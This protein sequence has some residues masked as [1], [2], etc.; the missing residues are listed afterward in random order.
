MVRNLLNF[1][2]FYQNTFLCYPSHPIYCALVQVS[3]L[4]LMLAVGWEG[5]GVGSCAYHQKWLAVML[6][7]ISGGIS[8]TQLLRWMPYWQTMCGMAC[9]QKCAIPWTWRTW[10]FPRKNDPMQKLWEWQT[11]PLIDKYFVLKFSLIYIS[12]V[13]NSLGYL[14]EIVSHVHVGMSF[15]C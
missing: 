5:T 1:L 13:Q 9:T 14:T 11:A 10:L 15:F 6:P 3:M 7:T 8:S 2:L 12:G 4:L